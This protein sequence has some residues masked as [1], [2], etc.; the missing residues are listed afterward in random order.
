[1]EGP[2]GRVLR[3]RVPDPQRVGPGGRLSRA[4]GLAGGFGARGGSTTGCVAA[5]ADG[6]YYVLGVELPRLPPSWGVHAPTWDA[7]TKDK[8]LRDVCSFALSSLPFPQSRCLQNVTCSFA[9]ATPPPPTLGSGYGGSSTFAS[10]SALNRSFRAASS[11]T[12]ATDPT[13]CG[14]R[15]TP[16]KRC[17]TRAS[18]CHGKL[19]GGVLRPVLGTVMTGAVI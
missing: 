18:A 17:C 13:P 7:P 2:E 10:A 6:N 12:R 16:F 19:T 14:V 8:R 1:M 9:L 4:E 15:S 5:R 11:L 3:G